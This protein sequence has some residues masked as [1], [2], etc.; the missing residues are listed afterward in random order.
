M[1]CFT[2]IDGDGNNF[3]SWYVGSNKETTLKTMQAYVILGSYNSVKIDGLTMFTLHVPY[4]KDHLTDMEHYDCLEE[5]TIRDMLGEL[6]TLDHDKNKQDHQ[7]FENV[8]MILLME[9]T[10]DFKLKIAISINENTAKYMYSK[11]VI[12]DDFNLDDL[13]VY[14]LSSR[15]L[16]HIILPTLLHHYG[17]SMTNPLYYCDPMDSEIVQS[18]YGSYTILTYM[19]EF[20]HQM[21]EIKD[22]DSKII[23]YINKTVKEKLVVIIG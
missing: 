3:S 16:F 14:L 5:L 20:M 6:L 21:L 9:I 4:I 12:D 8:K 11:L 1:K 19:L 17:N 7:L 13:C 2:G 23:E 22:D 15:Q 10:S 18:H